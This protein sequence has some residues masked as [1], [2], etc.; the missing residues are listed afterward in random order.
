MDDTH[1]RLV[2]N[3]TTAFDIFQAICTKYE[4]A[5]FHGDPYFIQH[6]VME[7]K[8]EEGGDLTSFFLEL[9]NA[10]K[11]ASEATESPL[12][13]G[14]KS[15]YLFHS[16]P[17]T[18]KDDLRVWKGVRKYIPYDELKMSIETKVREIQAQELQAS[19][20]V[21]V[22]SYCQKPRHNI[23]QCRTLQ[24]DLRDGCVKAGTVLPANF[25]L[26]GP[27]NYRGRGGG[28]GRGN[29]GGNR[30]NNGNN[31]NNGNNNGTNGNNNNKPSRRDEGGYDQSRRKETLIAV[32][33]NVQTAASA[34]SLTAQPSQDFDYSWTIDPAI[35]TVEL[36]ITDSKG[37]L[38]TLT[39]HDVLLAPKLQYNL[40]SVAA[41]VDD[42]FRFGFKR[43]VCTVQT[44]H[45][46]SIKAMKSATSKLYQFEASPLPKAEA[47]VATTG[48]PTRLML[49][50]KRLGHPN[51]RVLQALTKDQALHGCTSCS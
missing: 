30:K 36:Q 26:R 23:R 44:N 39:L 34:I 46:F 2:K 41:A 20:P 45:R 25:E 5:A 48:K 42:D 24:K 37:Q 13:D 19:V 7:I 32:V 40:L 8:Y 27:N 38:R 49:L 17:T 4:G 29:Y 9:E 33:S 28:R 15:L 11:A 31:G 51:I 1:I 50:H 47:H 21:D 43:T 18:W 3:L 22:C 12:T 10:M 14:Q 6:F 35:G 16:M